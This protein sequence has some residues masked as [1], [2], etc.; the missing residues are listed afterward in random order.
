MGRY[1]VELYVDER[2][3]SQIR[4]WLDDLGRHR[5]HLYGYA[6][7]L[8]VLLEDLGPEMRPPLAKPLRYL[9]APIWEL[10]HRSGIRMYYWR[11][12]EVVFVVAAGEVKKQDS[13]DPGLLE[14]TVRAY[15]ASQERG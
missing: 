2:G 3:R 1:R 10:R 14:L 15:K 4:D 13:P 5:P 6:Q 8:L 9:D 7:R 11:Q 12:D